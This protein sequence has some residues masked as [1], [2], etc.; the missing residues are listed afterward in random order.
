MRHGAQRDEPL[1]RRPDAGPRQ[2]GKAV[3]ASALIATGVAAASLVAGLGTY[4]FIRFTQ[5]RDT[6][7]DRGSR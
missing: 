2:P 4:L 7:A 5:R 6:T 3:R 1:G